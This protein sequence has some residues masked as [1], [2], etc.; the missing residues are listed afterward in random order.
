M[1]ITTCLPHLKSIPLLWL[2]WKKRSTWARLLSSYWQKMTQPNTKICSPNCK[3]PACRA[4][5]AC[6]KIRSFATLNLCAVV[7]RFLQNSCQQR[8]ALSIFV[9]N[10]IFHFY[11][12][13]NEKWFLP[14]SYS[15]WLNVFPFFF[16]TRC[17]NSLFYKLIKTSIHAATTF[18][19]LKA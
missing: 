6:L 13:K 10:F 18:K 15:A 16:P 2:N 11:S 4:V 14:P 17:T 12:F 8:H 3:Q 7:G 9:N 19:N 1:L 5:C